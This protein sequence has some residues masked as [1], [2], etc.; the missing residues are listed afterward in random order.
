[1]LDA[2]VQPKLLTLD[3]LLALGDARLEIIDGRIVKMPA[4][5]FAHHLI[6]GNIFR[7]LDPYVM[8]RQLGL[9]FFDGMTYLMLSEA[10]GLKDSF[11]PDVSFIWAANIVSMPDPN[12]PYPGIPDLAVEVIS[13]GD[14]AE[15]VQTTIRTYL[16]KGVEQVWI[17]YPTTREVHQYRRDNN[18]EIRIY[19][20]SQPLDLADLFPELEL[21]ADQ[22]FAVPPW[23]NK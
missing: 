14:D 23:A 3:E 18:P 17:V 5:G 8:Q 16:A 6:G 11:L 12:K 2:P 9:V 10:S 21:T 20:G 7:A 22:V 15:D 19:R 1:M 13:P 4:A